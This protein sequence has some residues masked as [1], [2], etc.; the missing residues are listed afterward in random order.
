MGVILTSRSDSNN[1]LQGLIDLVSGETVAAYAPLVFKDDFISSGAAVP[2]SAAAGTPWVAT[3][4]DTEGSPS[5]AYVSDV[6][7]GVIAVSL[8]DTSEAQTAALTMGDY[9][10]FDLTKGAILEARVALATVPAS[11][12]IAVW[13][14]GTAYNANPADVSDGVFFKVAG[15][16]A[17]NCVIINAGTPTSVSSGVRLTASAYHV[18]RIDAT[19][20]ANVQFFIDGVNV[21]NG[22]FTQTGTAAI[23]Q[24]YVEAYK[25]SGTDVA[26]IHVDMVSAVANR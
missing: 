25:A 22:A 13:G 10:S 14:L 6:D 24:P 16:G 15:S 19:N 18:F 23:T 20:A 11:A 8:D 17:V 9:R 12:A 2:T 4:V 5:V 7:G 1:N 3:L 26:V 21:A